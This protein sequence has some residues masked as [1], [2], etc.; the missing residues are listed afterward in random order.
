MPGRRR[1]GIELVADAGRRAE[2]ADWLAHKVRPLF[3]RRVLP[4]SEDV[5]LKWRLRP[6]RARRSARRSAYQPVARR[7]SSGASEPSAG[8]AA[9]PT[10][11]FTCSTWS[12]I[13]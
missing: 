3:D 13:R 4:V 10:W 7:S 5:M 9:L 11:T 6:A 2:L 12:S 1:T 8:W